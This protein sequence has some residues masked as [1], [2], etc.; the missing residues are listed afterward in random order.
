MHCFMHKSMLFWKINSEKCSKHFLPMV[1]SPS[2]TQSEATHIFPIADDSTNL[3]SIKVQY[4]FQSWRNFYYCRCIF[5]IFFISVQSFFDCELFLYVC[6]SAN[7]RFPFSSLYALN[8]R[9]R[10][11]KM[12]RLMKILPSDVKS[13]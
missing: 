7:T 1:S 10:G 5:Y 6:R 2:V 11:I 8:C 9:G 13:L 12:R 3:C 4:E